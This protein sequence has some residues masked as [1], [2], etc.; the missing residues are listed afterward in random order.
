[1]NQPIT[2]GTYRIK[3]V[4][5]DCFF[6]KDVQYAVA[7]KAGN[8]TGCSEEVCRVDANSEQQAKEELEKCLTNKFGEGGVW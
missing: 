5:Y 8:I 7:E 4:A 2:V 1:M 3:G 6:F